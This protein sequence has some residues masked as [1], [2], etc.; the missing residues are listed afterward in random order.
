MVPFLKGLKVLDLSR[1]ISG[2]FAGMLLGDLGADVI[3]VEKAGVGDDTRSFEPKIHGESIYTFAVNRSKRSL[4]LNF[5]TKEGQSLLRDLAKEADVLI[6]NFRPGT[7]EKMGCGWETLHEIN[8]RLIM[9]SI[10]G[11]GSKGPYRDK[12]GFDAAIQAMSGLMS[13][14]G[15]PDGPPMVHGTFTVDHV[16]A[17]YA[18]YA[19]LAVYIGRQQN[20]Q[21]QLIELSLLE[22]AATLLLS[23]IPDQAANGKIASRVGNQD[24]YLSPGNCYRTMDGAHILLIAG[25]QPHFKALCEAMDQTDLLKDERFAKQQARFRHRD[26]IDRI[27]GAWIAEKR[28]EEVQLIL[29]QHGLVCSRVE[30]TADL[31]KNPQLRYRKKLIQ[32]EHPI[33]GNVTMMDMPYHFSALDIPPQRACPV[34]GQHNEEVLKDWLRL[35][36][37][38]L[39][40]LKKRHA[41]TQ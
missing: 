33:M 27:V 12:P 5:R 11:F 30:N 17:I 31:I 32:I 13:V 9:V 40:E 14:T 37:V 3:K 2:P 25:S 6:E 15:D 41:I 28:A 8:P 29:E 7:M 20:G 18:A 16:T 26:E 35:D 24:R 23:S 34:L 38:Q 4:E 10:S 19:I 39:E 36:D 21:G 22:C 1:Y